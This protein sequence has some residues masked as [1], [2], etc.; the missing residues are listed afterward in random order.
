MPSG[1]KKRKSSKKPK[2]SSQSEPPELDTSFDEGMAK[3]GEDMADGPP[4][5]KAPVG[6]PEAMAGSGLE[7]KEI[8]GEVLQEGLVEPEEIKE[9]SQTDGAFAP[10]HQQEICKDDPSPQADP[11]PDIRVVM[12]EEAPARIE[13][14]GE[15][16]I[17]ISQGEPMLQIKPEIAMP[18]SQTDT[19]TDAEIEREMET[20]AAP[21]ACEDDTGAAPHA[22]ADEFKPEADIGLDE[23]ELSIES[24]PVGREPEPSAPPVVS[25]SRMD[26]SPVE[27]TPE[28]AA[29]TA[30]EGDTDAAADAP[31]E[32]EGN[33]GQDEIE[34][35]IGSA[36]EERESEPAVSESRMDESPVET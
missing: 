15:A 27:T 29:P 7:A 26:E 23:I 17:E 32:T 9:G 33:I 19:A 5:P 16:P 10:P 24:A 22:P 2:S 18:R 34:L 30:F 6:D 1:S 12:D 35:S 8:N 3:E 28:D 21:T 20:D 31:A 4:S 36:P 13:P 25:E 14:E 11:E